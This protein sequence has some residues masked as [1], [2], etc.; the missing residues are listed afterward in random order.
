MRFVI[1]SAP[2][3]AMSRMIR[4]IK[5]SESGLWTTMPSIVLTRNWAQRDEDGG[6]DEEEQK[7]FD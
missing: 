3:L 6:G 4:P 2:L 5:V 1:S 7:P